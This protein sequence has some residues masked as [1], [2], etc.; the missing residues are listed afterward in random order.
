MRDITIIHPPIASMAGISPPAINQLFSSYFL[1][2]GIAYSFYDF[3]LGYFKQFLDAGVFQEIRRNNEKE[4]ARYEKASDT[5]E[6]EGYMCC[7]LDSLLYESMSGNEPL[8]FQT[9][10]FS[11][12]KQEYNKMLNATYDEIEEL[13]EC[14]EALPSIHEYIDEICNSDE[15]DELCNTKIAGVSIAHS[16]QTIPAIRIAREVKR[17]NPDSYVV[18]GGSQITMTYEKFSKY[19]FMFDEID[20][21]GVYS[22]ENTLCDLLHAID[23]NGDVDHIPNLVTRG[24]RGSVR[25]ECRTRL[26]DIDF[27]IPWSEDQISDYGD[28]PEIKIVCAKGCYW[29]RCR[30]CNTIICNDLRRKYDVRSAKS[31][32]DEIERY[33]KLGIVTFGFIAQSIPRK[34]LAEI[35]S[36]IV[37]RKLRI[38]II[39][40]YKIDK[41]VSEKELYKFFCLLKKA[42]ISVLYVGAEAVENTLLESADKGYDTEDVLSTMRGMT[43]SGIEMVE[44]GFIPDLPK[45]NVKIWNETKKIINANKDIFGGIVNS[46]F[47]LVTK[48]AYAK[49]PD[50]YDIEILGEDKYLKRL[51]PYRHKNISEKT[52]KRILNEAEAIEREMKIH[53]IAKRPLRIMGDPNTDIGGAS[54]IF[55]RIHYRKIKIPEEAGLLVFNAESKTMCRMNLRLL[56]L[57][58]YINRH[59]G[60]TLSLGEIISDNSYRSKNEC[61]DDIRLLAKEGFLEQIINC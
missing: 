54:F 20:A 17:R 19:Y 27:K 14:K 23:E 34:R 61:V 50:K 30:F 45:I 58:D 37:K 8:L 29:R 48:S 56:G 41:G 35:A 5:T 31:I 9:V 55:R 49:E 59:Q 60:K 25:V 22:G 16:I 4:I 53:R 47:E 51:L 32:V 6:L 26:D 3:D 28:N 46:P 18:L 43:E 42:G 39:A 38:R 36:E 10:Y 44:M 21:L 24:N 40:N 7:L 12:A 33:A 52:H 15:F 57:I 11:R 13:I 1:D 2:R